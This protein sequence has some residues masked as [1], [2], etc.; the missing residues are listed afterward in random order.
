MAATSRNES[1]QGCRQNN[2]DIETRPKPRI[3]ASGEC[4]TVS[5]NPNVGTPVMKYIKLGLAL[6]FITMQT[7]AAT[8]LVD[9]IKVF[10]LPSSADYNLLPWRTGTE[11][12][13]ISWHHDGIRNCPQYLRNNHSLCRNGSSIVH[14]N[15]KAI[16]MVL[17]RR[18]G[19]APWQITLRGSR[20][21]VNVVSLDSNVLSHEIG[22]N[23]LEHAIKNNH[24]LKITHLHRCGEISG[25]KRLYRVSTPARKDA[26]V[27]EWWS[28]GSGGCSADLTIFF[29]K[30]DAELRSSD[31]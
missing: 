5:P 9:L 14:I 24:V 16:P 22:T 25:G 10:M 31:C 26:F 19:P 7:A 29:V 4:V 11:V 18:M 23:F 17:K 21:G 8:E 3:C 20:A 13:A 27:Q 28:C 15:G 30:E 1:P 12:Q 2:F 6:S